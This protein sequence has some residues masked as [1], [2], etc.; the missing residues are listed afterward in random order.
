MKILVICVLG[1]YLFSCSKDNASRGSTSFDMM[2][3]GL[4]GGTLHFS[5]YSDADSSNEYSIN[6]RQDY[7]STNPVC[8]IQPDSAYYTFY[9]YDFTKTD[10]GTVVSE[11][12]FGVPAFSSGTTENDIAQ[13][14]MAPNIISG[15][16]VGP[17]FTFGKMVITLNLSPSQD[18][19]TNGTFDVTGTDGLS[20]VHITGSFRGLKNL[21]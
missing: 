2:V 19:E 13:S 18:V 17:H 10:S 9:F 6:G 5:D 1:F 15:P 14:N 11:V 7:L 8:W 12:S 3:T 16:R 20:Q 4:P 21:K